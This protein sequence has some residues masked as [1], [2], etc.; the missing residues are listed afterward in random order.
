[1]IKKADDAAAYS[2]AICHLLNPPENLKNMGQENINK[3]KMFYS[4]IVNE[5][6]E[7]IYQRILAG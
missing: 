7:K 3:I 2:Q 5:K 4:N 1:M 6:M